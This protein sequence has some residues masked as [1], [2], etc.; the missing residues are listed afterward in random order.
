MFKNVTLNMLHLNIKKHWIAHGTNIY[1]FEHYATERK[2][3]YF[4]WTGES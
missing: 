1:L 4:L 3:T 2:I